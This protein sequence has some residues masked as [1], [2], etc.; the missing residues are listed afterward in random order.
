M[1]RSRMFRISGIYE[2]LEL[3][4]KYFLLKVN[5]LLQMFPQSYFQKKKLFPQSQ[6]VA[7]SAH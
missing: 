5:Y 6:I 1:F 7:F 4:K 3:Q 2:A